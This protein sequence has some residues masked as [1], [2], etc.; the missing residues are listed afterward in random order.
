M[1]TT[2]HAMTTIEH[3]P[4]PPL[5][6]VVLIASVRQPRLGHLL[7]TWVSTQVPE[8]HEV[9]LI[10]LAEVELPSDSLLQPGGGPSTSLTERLEAADG[11]ILVTPEYNASFP[12]PLKRAIDWH[13]SQWQFKAAMIV[14][15]GVQGGWRAESQ[16]RMVLSELSV[17]T[18]RR[19]LG[20][21]APWES[22]TPAG[23]AP[24]PNLKQALAA[25]LSE[26]AWWAQTLRTA[27]VVRPFAG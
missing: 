18:T 13:Y 9:E 19:S 4:Q 3:A 15:Y 25:G 22:T 17:V 24:D 27:R 11:F 10:D 14:S 21:R 23:F 7:G 26:L 12:A 20:I 5:K 1:T 2:E 16:L 8:P 6:Y